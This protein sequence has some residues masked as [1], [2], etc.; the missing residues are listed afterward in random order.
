MLMYISYTN[1][2]GLNK[3]TR[4]DDVLLHNVWVLSSKIA[5]LQESVTK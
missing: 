1:K 2:I 3:T 5:K 4:G